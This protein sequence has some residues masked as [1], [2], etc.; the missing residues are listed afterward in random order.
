[1][2][3]FL[4]MA[5]SREA[6]LLLRDHVEALLHRL[7]LHRNATKG[8]WEPIQ[9]GDHLGLTIDLRNNEFRAPVDKLQALSKHASTLLGRAATTAR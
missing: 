6:A 3:D 9:V 4:F 8:L 1:M 2:D 7:G 5:N